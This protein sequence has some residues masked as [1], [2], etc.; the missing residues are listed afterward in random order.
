MVNTTAK[1]DLVERLRH[2]RQQAREL[3]E[4]LQHALDEGCMHLTATDDIAGME[5]FEQANPQQ[6]IDAARLQLQTGFM[7]AERAIEQPSEF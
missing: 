7:M 1:R 3:I 2:Q 6:W 4:D 5:A